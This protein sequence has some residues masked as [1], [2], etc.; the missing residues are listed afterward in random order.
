LR[1]GEIAAVKI[2]RADAYDLHGTAV[3]YQRP[4][5]LHRTIGDGMFAAQNHR[6]FHATPRHDQDAYPQRLG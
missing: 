4:F 6:T 2:E 5:R 1:V 3:G